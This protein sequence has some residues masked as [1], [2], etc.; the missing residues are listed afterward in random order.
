MNIPINKWMDCAFRSAIPIVLVTISLALLTT[1]FPYLAVLPALSLLAILWLGARKL[2]PYLFYGIVLLIPFGAYRGLG[3]AFAFVR[4]HWIFAITLAGVISIGALLHKRIPEELRQG[5]FWAFVFL[6]YIINLISA[7]GSKYPEASA[8]FMLLMSAGYLLVALGMIVVDK[9]GFSQTLPRIIVGSIC[10]SSLLVLAGAVLKIP[11]FVDTVSGRAMGGSSD[12]NNTALMTIF[13]LPLAVYFLLTARRPLIQQGMLLVIAMD[14]AA[15][16][17]TFSRGGALILGIA[18]LLMFLEF[19]HFIVPHN[20]GLLM[21]LGGLALVALLLLTPDAY[22]Q[23]IQSVSGADDFSMRRR[24]SYLKVAA[25]SI[26]ARPFFGSGPDTFSAI[27]A[28]SKIGRTFKRRN[29]SGERKAHNTYAEVAVGSGLFGIA[30][31]AALLIYS[32]NSFT[33]AKHRFLASGQPHLALLT[34]AFR[35]SLL[36]LLAYLLIHSDLNHKYLL[37]SL[38]VS[39]I[40]LRI[41]KQEIT[42]D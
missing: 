14:V 19:R 15:V 16:I 12:P 9:K 13:S 33:K 8:P 2:F 37:V 4:L 5:R 24:S 41:S 28:D 25:K 42:H 27:Y 20:I 18:M 7:F 36:S 38:A 23:R 11:F 30:S 3:G 34:A 32:I 22:I 31:L 26:V 39:Q 1:P 40:A 6:F 21:G 10:V 29:V 35:T 17:A